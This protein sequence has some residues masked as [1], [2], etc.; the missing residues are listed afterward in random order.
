MNKFDITSAPLKGETVIE[1]SAGTGKTYAIAGLFLR[2]IVEGNLKVNQI[3]VVTFTVA[4]TDELR[5]RI[6][7]RLREGLN[8]L[9]DGYQGSD[10]VLAWLAGKYKNNITIRN[11]L[12]E[13]IIC[14]DEAAIFTIHGFCQKL[15]SE[16]AFE[17]STL[18]DTELLLDDSD[19]L[20]EVCR[21]YYR[22]HFITM[23]PLLFSNPQIKQITPDSLLKLIKCLSIDP[24][25]TII[26]KITDIC[27][28]PN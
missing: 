27:D 2:L 13:A 18:F 25:F 14:F 11:R 23:C 9:I 4:A 1:A 16:N 6:R 12:K 26:P 19:I 8:A 21:D 17:S 10:S 7:R 28:N 15:L 5:D 3:L 24:D 20:I 22:R